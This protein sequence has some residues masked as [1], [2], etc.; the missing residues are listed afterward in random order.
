MTVVGK[1]SLGRISDKKGLTSGLVLFCSILGA[2]VALLFGASLVWVAIV[3]GIIYGI[4]NAV[5]TVMPPLMT[6]ACAGLKHF[7]PIYGIM[8]I[9]QT[10]GS[11]LGMPL[12]GYI[13][14]KTGNYN[15][16]FGLYLAL[17]LLAAITGAYALKNAKFKS[18]N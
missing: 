14:D 17:C 5:Q 2:G 11:G 8:A 6:A 15:I 7:A 3:W 18:V 12:S 9:F 4:G 10:L 16:A 1:L 13:F